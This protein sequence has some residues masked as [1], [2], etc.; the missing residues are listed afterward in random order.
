MGSRLLVIALVAILFGCGSNS[1]RSATGAKIKFRPYD[2]VDSKQGGLVVS[3]FAIPEDWK[4]GARVTWNY[5]DLYLPVHVAAR[6]EAPDGS[7]WIEFYPAEIFVWLDPAHDRSSKGPGS[8][9]IH[10]PGI[11]LPEAL[12]RYVVVRNR[13]RAQNLRII[14]TRR[15]DNMAKAFPQMFIGVPPKGEAMCMR[16][17]YKLDG[18]PVD[19]EFYAFMSDLMTLSSSGAAGLIHEYHRTMYLVHSMGAKG[20]KLESLRPLLGFMA[21]SIQP[22]PAWQTRLAD[23][24]KMQNDSNQRNL[25]ATYAGIRAAVARSHAISAQNDQFIRNIEASR[26]AQK[27]TQAA[28]GTR[29]QANE[30][31]ETQNDG[32]TQYQRGTEHMQDQNG[33]VSDLPNNYNYHWADGFGQFVHTNDANLDPN[34]YLTGNYQ[35]MSPPPQ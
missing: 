20:G 28:P 6:A 5:N 23:I 12:V 21:T 2:V 14:G 13:R 9:G 34:H 17:Q 8:G 18:V 33:V 4:G 7:S 26:S 30:D 19:E 31:I 22:N 16:V 15:V 35:K 32:F 3:R 24:Q 27:Q 25:A 11:T 29:T 1:L 10:H